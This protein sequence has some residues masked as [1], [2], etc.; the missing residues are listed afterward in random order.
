MYRLEICYLEQH[1]VTK[2]ISHRFSPGSRVFIL[3]T[4]L[5]QKRRVACLKGKQTIRSKHRRVE[6]NPRPSPAR[7]IPTQGIP[8]GTGRSARCR[9]LRDCSWWK[10]HHWATAITGTHT[11]GCMDILHL[12]QNFLFP[13]CLEKYKNRYLYLYL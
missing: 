2:N 8:V 1:N 4:S 7:S 12:K 6:E 10:W 5:S 9:K 3:I 11:E 13:F